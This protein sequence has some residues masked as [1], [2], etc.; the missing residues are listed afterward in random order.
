MSAGLNSLLVGGHLTTPCCYQE[1][2]TRLVECSQLVRYYQSA[3][4][5]DLE[6]KMRSYL[7]EVLKL[8]IVVLEIHSRNYGETETCQLAS[9]AVAVAVGAC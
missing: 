2:T 1:C 4:A 8:H 3:A 6:S 5:E 9:A 7:K